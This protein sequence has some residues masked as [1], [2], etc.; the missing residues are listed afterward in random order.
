M[1]LWAGAIM[2][3]FAILLF[4]N[5]ISTSI[6]ARQKEIGILRA[7]GARSLDIYWIYGFESLI[8]ALVCVIVSSSLTFLVCSLLNRSLMSV[9]VP[10]AYFN[11]DALVVLLLFGSA[12]LTAFVSSF[13]PAYRAAKKPPVEAIRS[14]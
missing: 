12:V 4:A 10:V 7:L 11:P 1:L 2:L 8:V 13:I 14:L 9:V 5:L 6:G 3:F